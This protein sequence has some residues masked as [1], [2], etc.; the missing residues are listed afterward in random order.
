[1]KLAL[2]TVQFGFNY[3]IANTS[4]Q[5]PPE[6]IAAILDTARA[7]GID[8]ID[9]AI[10]YGDSEARLGIAGLAGF[11]VISKLPPLNGDV[12]S[13]PALVDASLQR[14]GRTL[15]DGLM[16]HRSADL[17]GSSGA[18]VYKLMVALK[19]SGTVSKIGVSIYDPEELATV[20]GRYPIDLVQA[21][22]NVFDRRLAQSGWL[23]RLKAEN[24]EVHTR[25][26]FLQGLLLMSPGDRPGKFARW[27]EI[28]AR[29]EK[30]IAT[31]G[32]TRLEAALGFA[33]GQDGVDRVV[34]GVD[35]NRQ[36]I[37]VVGASRASIPHAPTFLAEDEPMLTN[38]A[39]WQRI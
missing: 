25:S 32:L 4:G 23:D 17:A 12:G 24:V 5:V 34:V 36:F 20:V 26:A 9:T 22:F 18:E 7:V 31:S 8:T 2:G 29:W 10:A 21:P 16:L 13:V 39:N 15:L 14:L 19:A 27:D 1:V 38:P 6:E 3:G 37:G 11:R 30:W 28:F 33:C 35:S